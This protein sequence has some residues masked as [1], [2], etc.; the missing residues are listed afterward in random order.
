MATVIKFSLPRM[1]ATLRKSYRPADPAV[2]ELSRLLA[3]AASTARA[4]RARG[5]A[6][7][8]LNAINKLVYD[9]KNATLS[10]RLTQLKYASSYPQMRQL[11]RTAPTGGAPIYTKVVIQGARTYFPFLSRVIRPGEAPHAKTGGQL[12][13][14]AERVASIMPKTPAELVVALQAHKAHL[15]VLRD[16]VERAK[17]G[18]PALAPRLAELEVAYKEALQSGAALVTASKLK[19]ANMAGM[20]KK[21]R[22]VRLKD[23]QE[24]MARLSQVSANIKKAD[25]LSKALTVQVARAPSVQ[26]RAQ[27]TAR[28]HAN[29]T[30]RGALV[31]RYKA[32]RQGEDVVP[33]RP[34]TVSIARPPIGLFTAIQAQGADATAPL[35]P[36]DPVLRRVIIR[37]LGAKLPKRAG[38][39]RCDF[40]ERLR[41]YSKRAMARYLAN[42]AKGLDATAA[43]E[44]AVVDTI[45]QDT[46]ALEAEVSA[47]GQAVDTEA[48]A[49][50]AL[51]DSMQTDVEQAATDL[52]PET[53]ANS[54]DS[55]YTSPLVGEEIVISA[56]EATDPAFVDAQLDAS[57]AE[58][59]VSGNLD[60]SPSATTEDGETLIF[61][62]ARESAAEDSAAGVGAPTTWYKNPF[63]IGAAVL[64]AAFALGG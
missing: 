62:D 33:V 49:V 17:A 11:L 44:T 6:Y 34:V 14:L 41:M 19:Q 10:L 13:Q 58:L 3:M 54:P 1:R 59:A 64:A 60:L 38:E 35:P 29:R 21:C 26:L 15:A 56:A 40:V 51:V 2:V 48:D 32:L 55:A 25:E 4:A 12:V 23:K 36:I 27:M 37:Y 53:A 42:Q 16:Q 30:A 57:I 8:S 52:A 43:A 45:T 24:Q 9:A 20:I 31:E 46:A 28:L 7:D 61:Q 5:V 39:S 18:D 47:G 63:V 50:A 22:R